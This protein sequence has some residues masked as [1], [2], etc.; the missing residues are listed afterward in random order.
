MNTFQ[1]LLLAK[2]FNIHQ[3]CKIFTWNSLK[4]KYKTQLL[5]TKQAKLFKLH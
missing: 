2:M 5:F 1:A 3:N 4:V